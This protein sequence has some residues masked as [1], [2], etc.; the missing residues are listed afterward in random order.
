MKIMFMGTP[1]F[2]VAS[3]RALVESNAGEITVITQPD[4]PKGRKMILTPPEVK[5]YAESV[6]LPVYQPLTLKGEEFD[7]FLHEKA[8][9]I[10]IV[11]AYGKILPKSV[12]DY[13]KYGCINVHGS[14]LPK[15]RGAAP[16]QRSLIDGESETGITIMYMDVGLDTG[17]M[18]S[19]TAVPISPD[20]NAETLFDKMAKA[21]A[22]LLL[23]TLPNIVGGSITREKQNESEATYASKVG[24]DDCLIDFKMTAKALHDR[25]RGLSPYLYAYALRGEAQIKLVKTALTDKKTDKAEG[26]L[27]SDGKKLYVSCRDGELLELVTVLPAGK[28]QMS[29]ADY[30][31]GNPVKDG[32]KLASAKE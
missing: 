31:R 10:I 21:G 30:L 26:T 3:L 5:V 20:D 23:S 8:P 27:I 13:P 18:I 4:K 32:E 14:L 16:V 11:A 17:D 1:D 7:S 6:G 22:S 29:A 19:K 28:K 15:Y 2:A 12:I 24:R 9:D 25:V